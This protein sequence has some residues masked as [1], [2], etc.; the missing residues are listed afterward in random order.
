MGDDTSKD[1]PEADAAVRQTGHE[2]TGEHG[3]G[4]GHGHAEGHGRGHGHVGGGPLSRLWGQVKHAVTPHSHDSADIVDSTL[5]A[6]ARGMRTL[7]ISFAGLMVT[8]VAQL[9]VVLISGSVALLGDTLHNFAD[10]LTAVPLAI[11]FLLGRRAATRR[12]TYGLGRSEDLAGLVILLVMFASAVLAAWTAIDRLLNPRDMT[13]IGWVAAAGV[14][15]FLGNEIVARYRITV[16]RQIGSAALVA[17]GL[18]ARTDGFTSLAVL[19][20]AGG[21]WLGWRWADPVVGLLITTAILSVLWGAAKE[22]FSRMLDAV[23]PA[24]VDTAEQTLAA[25]PGVRGVD[26][27][28]LRWVGHSLIAESE[29]DVDPTLTLLQAHKIAHDAEHRLIHAL[30]RLNEAL[31]H[32][33]PGGD[34]G[35]DH[36]AAVR[37]HS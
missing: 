36:H 3:H 26:T 35:A 27:I 32:A 7:W 30:P 22:V 18:H 31:I 13:E 21:S 20:A 19:L 14:V 23:D 33:H 34:A 17:D 12:F 6:S 29:L 10:A 8:A 28:R 16:G 25:T 37:Q 9:V 2:P 15:G 5:E 4:H 1:T 24:L 11:A